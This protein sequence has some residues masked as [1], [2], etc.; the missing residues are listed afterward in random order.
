MISE[1]TCDTEDWSDDAANS[2]LIIAINY[3][4]QIITNIFFHRKLLFEIETIHN[5]YCIFDQINITLVS[6]RGFFKT[7]KKCF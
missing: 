4:L 6:R 5:F 7:L 1:E 2:A 3:I